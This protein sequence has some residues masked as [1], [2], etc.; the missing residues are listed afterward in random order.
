MSPEALELA[1]KRIEMEMRDRTCEFERAA[2]KKHG[3]A[4]RRGVGISSMLIRSIHALAR[5][6]LEARARSALATAQR[7]FTADD[8]EP[9][10]ELRAEVIGLIDRALGELS[11]DVDAVYAKHCS[12]MKGKWPTLE[13]PRQRALNLA[14]SDLDIVLL[15]RRRKQVPVGD[16]L[17]APRYE[18]CREHWLKA[19]G[20][21]DAE[22]LDIENA[23]KEGVSAVEA[24]AKVVTGS[25][26]TLGDCIKTL[27]AER[28]IDAGTDKILEGLWTFAN[29]APGVRHGSGTPSDLSVREWQ[30]FAP[31]VDGAL[32]LLLSI[33][34]AN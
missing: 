18:V 1:E 19:R 6:E 25:G 31:M 13:E 16:A 28:R 9:S 24:L 4:S 15:T 8:A 7:A 27:R 21:G 3:E 22:V 32:I 20:L 14:T 2:L 33:D 29:S 17:K 23:I 5:T 11:S 34:N 12:R 10:D 26:A 30:I